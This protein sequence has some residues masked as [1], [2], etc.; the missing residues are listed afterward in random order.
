MIT[1]QN[2]ILFQHPYRY[3]DGDSEDLLNFDAFHIKLSFVDQ[4]TV[5]YDVI[6][7]IINIHGI[8]M[9]DDSKNLFIIVFKWNK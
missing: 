8:V 2:R 3:G 1:I 4:F 6:I 5:F 9:L 7:V